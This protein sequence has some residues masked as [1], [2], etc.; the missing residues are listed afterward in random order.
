MYADL[1]LYHSPQKNKRYSDRNTKLAMGQAGE[2]YGIFRINFSAFLQMGS[3]LTNV[4]D[5]RINI[6]RYFD[7]LPVIQCLAIR[8]HSGNDFY[9]MSAKW[10]FSSRNHYICETSYEHAFFILFV[11]HIRM[12][13]IVGSKRIVS[14]ISTVRSSSIISINFI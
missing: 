6:A 13:K 7:I 11:M 3:Y 9:L 4:F 10:K 1:M 12:N 8:N 5:C 2:L 14:Q